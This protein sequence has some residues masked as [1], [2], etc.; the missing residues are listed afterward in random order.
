M[1]Q[2]ERLILRRW[3][4]ADRAP[5]AVINADPELAYWLGGSISRAQNDANIDRY[6][7]CIDGRGF[8][9][10]AVERK[11][12]HALVG[13]VGAMPISEGLGMAG[14]EIGWRIARPAWGAGYAREAARAALDDGL[15]RVGLSEVVAFTTPA[16]LRSLSVMKAIGMVHDPA[17]DFEHP[18]LP[19]GH[20]LR[21]LVVFVVRA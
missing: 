4:E 11:A 18:A 20:P 14:H 21:R 5:Y 15:N 19:K 6:N 9:R 12:D 16:N 8:G 7:A 3:C 13:A 2:T 1:I 10:W 17:R